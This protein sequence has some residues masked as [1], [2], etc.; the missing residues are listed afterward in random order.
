MIFSINPASAGSGNKASTI[1]F[2]LF[3]NWPQLLSLYQ[4]KEVFVRADFA[5][6]SV[7]HK[8]YLYLVK[9][10]EGHRIVQLAIVS[11]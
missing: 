6:T 2:F 11:I 10:S 3:I 1:L 8:L 4:L 5:L 7:L 9:F